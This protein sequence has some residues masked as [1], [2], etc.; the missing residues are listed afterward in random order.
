MLKTSACQRL[1]RVKD[2][3]VL[4]TSA[5]QRLLRLG[6]SSSSSSK[7]GSS[8]TTKFLLADRLGGDLRVFFG[9][10]GLDLYASDCKTNR[11]CV[12]FHCIISH[13]YIYS[14]T[15]NL[16]LQKIDLNISVYN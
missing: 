16:F 3:S 14:N 12:T 15:F 4:K 9:P 2:F 10:L 5:C 1:Q 13:L 7:I 11:T 6:F 8:V